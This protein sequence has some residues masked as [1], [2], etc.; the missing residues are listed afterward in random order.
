MFGDFFKKITKLPE[1]TDVQV[2]ML[3]TRDS[4]TVQH[5]LQIAQNMKPVYS[6]VC[7]YMYLYRVQGSQYYMYVAQFEDCTKF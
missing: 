4:N 1:C 6:Y 3:Y 2:E 5:N 7:I